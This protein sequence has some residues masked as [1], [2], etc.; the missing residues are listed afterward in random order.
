MHEIWVLCPLAT[1]CWGQTGH[2]TNGRT[3]NWAVAEGPRDAPRQLKPCKKLY[4]CSTNSICKPCNC[5]MTFKVIR[6][7]Y[8]WRN[9]IGNMTLPIWVLSNL[10]P[11][12]PLIKTKTGICTSLKS[13]FYFRFCWSHTAKST[14]LNFYSI[15]N[16]VLIRQKLS[17]WNLKTAKIEIH[18]PMLHV[19]LRNSIRGVVQLITFPS[20]QAKFSENR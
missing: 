11:Y 19:C 18:T 14:F 10:G 12:N 2:I 1:V 16:F 7:H 9:S 3:K 20:Q 15:Q 5:R 13:R 6:C 17:D 4:K 8:K